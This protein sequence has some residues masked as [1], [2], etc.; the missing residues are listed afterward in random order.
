G[1]PI[2]ALTP[3][4]R[5]VT[6]MSLYRAVS[7]VHMSHQPSSRDELL[8][9]AEQLLIREGVVEKGNFI[10]ITAGE[11]MG[12]SGGTNTMKIVRVGEQKP[13]TA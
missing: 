1:V 4:A 13:P 10:V 8:Y 6:K 11:P 2:Y 3:R 12:N 7:P 9:E 5:A